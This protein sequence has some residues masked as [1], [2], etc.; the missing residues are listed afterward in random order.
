[1]STTNTLTTDVESSENLIS[2]NI[3]ETFANYY[4]T[5][6]TYEKA[7]INIPS[8]KVEISE[9]EKQLKSADAKIIKAQKELAQLNNEKVPNYIDETRLIKL[10]AKKKISKLKEEVSLR[11]KELTNE[12]DKLIR[13]SK[14]NLNR[15]LKQLLGS[16]DGTL[17]AIDNEFDEK[18]IEFTRQ[19]AS[20]M[21]KHDKIVS[22][23]NEEINN[24]KAIYKEEVS[25]LSEKQQGVINDFA[26]SIEVAQKIINDIIESFRSSVNSAEIQL[27]SAEQARNNELNKLN[28]ERQN[29]VAG[30]NSQISRLQN[31][32]K[33]TEKDYNRQIAEIQRTNRATTRIVNSRQV[34]LNKISLE[35]TKC[36]NKRDSELSKMDIK[37]SDAKSKLDTKVNDAKNNLN[38]I[39]FMREEKLEQPRASLSTLENQRDEKVS[40][41]E[42]KI[43][44]KTNIRDKAINDLQTEIDDVERNRSSQI[45]ELDE[46]MK[47][48]AMSGD[49]CFDEILND[50][51]KPFIDMTQHIPLWEIN[52]QKLSCCKTKN[53]LAKAKNIVENKLSKMTY[54][55]LLLIA[56]SAEI[57]NNK[58]GIIASSWLAVLGGL[59]TITCA[60]FCILIFLVNWNIST[61]TIVSCIIFASI[62]S[63]YKYISNKKINE[64]ITYLL[65]AKEYKNLKAIHSH[66][67]TMTEKLETAKLRERGDL[68]LVKFLG[69]ESAKKEHQEYVDKITKEFENKIDNVGTDIKTEEEKIL[70][71]CEQEIVSLKLRI[72][73]LLNQNDSSIQEWQQKFSSANAERD[74]IKYLI[75]DLIEKKELQENL[76]KTFPNDYKRLEE[77]IDQ[78]AS[79]IKPSD[80][81]GALPNPL[82][83]FSRTSDENSI[84]PIS[85]LVHNMKP[86][87]L[88]YDTFDKGNVLGHI[89]SF[90]KQMISS[91]VISCS[92]ELREQYV[93]DMVTGAYDYNT[94]TFK[95]LKIYAV[96]N[97]SDLKNILIQISKERNA[98]NERLETLPEPERNLA[99]LNQELMRNRKRI[100]P[101]RILH[102]IIP[103]RDQIDNA[104]KLLTNEFKQ[105]LITDKDTDGVLI[106]FYIDE[107][108]WNAT[109]NDDVKKEEDI[110]YLI[111]KSGNLNDI[112][113]NIDDELQVLKKI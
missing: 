78:K 93:V 104:N 24:I 54:D 48:F 88:L 30:Y 109:E 76:M 97:E 99:V 47:Q 73:N 105:L 74:N 8:I 4:E 79:D 57:I 85:E 71:A 5:Y 6:Q 3:I 15:K 49:T 40:F 20:I 1:M 50:A 46:Q 37:I 10:E 60:I 45:A 84:A 70:K 51:F 38:N 110:I 112:V 66:S 41:I 95:D 29:I 27:S 98:V 13:S 96:G 64:N 28:N 100:F 11:E 91:I 23:K 17:I 68:L 9:Y 7:K 14:E 86:T 90:F 63:L 22:E 52:E 56:K 94:Q 89:S 19:R 65:L 87:V 111:K 31:E 58:V 35:T 107:T 33:Q 55:D 83:L 25:V 32:Y 82:Y 80:T 26:P 69:P 102:I 101:Y 81:F 72:D 106:L 43:E 36:Q 12:R 103:K 108:E 61:A 16:D 92:S 39:V 77:Y 34:H 62:Y 59:T 44:N 42:N 75:S 53:G 67:Q 113:Y 2:E 21:E 18:A